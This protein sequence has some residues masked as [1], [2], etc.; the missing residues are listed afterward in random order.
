LIT[1]TGTPHE[2]LMLVNNDGNV[3]LSRKGRSRHQ[4]APQSGPVRPGKHQFLIEQL[5]QSAWGLSAIRR[6]P[7]GKTVVV[8]QPRRDELSGSRPRQQ[9][10]D[11]SRFF[12]ITSDK[13]S[14]SKSAISKRTRR[15]TGAI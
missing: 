4:L 10:S 13:P 15:N 6:S 12:S 7:T 11:W 9:R 1:T 14:R 2:L 8:D 5:S 3:T